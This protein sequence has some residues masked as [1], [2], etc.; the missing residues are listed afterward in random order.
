MKTR[1]IVAFVLLSLLFVAFEISLVVTALSSQAWISQAIAGAGVFVALIAA[2]IALHSADRKEPKIQAQVV[3]SIDRSKPLTHVRDE[4]PK[5]QRAQLTHDQE[6]FHSEKVNFA[7]TNETGFTLR[8]PTLAFRLPLAKQHPHRLDGG[9]WT[10]GFNSNLYNFQD[11]L[12]ILKFGDTAILSNSNL[13]FWNDGDEF[14]FWIR[15]A[16][17]AGGLEPFEVEVSF[18]ATN[19]EGIT[20]PVEVD[21]SEQAETQDPGSA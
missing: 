16:L 10:V 15:M 12:R 8:E 13:P 1:Y 5:T 18:N 20:V 21:P 14:E 2:I 9:S 6:V 11:E 19:A 17:D 4:I 7:I 3:V